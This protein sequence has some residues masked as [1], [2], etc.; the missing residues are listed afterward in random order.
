MFL[1]H[2][3]Y[4]DWVTMYADDAARDLRKRTLA[5]EDIDGIRSLWGAK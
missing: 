1:S 5:A 2:E 4:D 3:L